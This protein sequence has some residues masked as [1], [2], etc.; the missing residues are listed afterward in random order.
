MA[1]GIPGLITESACIFTQ[2]CFLFVSNHSLFN[3][4]HWSPK[5]VLAWII[6]DDL[7]KSLV[8]S[9]KILFSNKMELIASM[10]VSFKKPPFNHLT[11][12]YSS[13]KEIWKK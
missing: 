8:T 5:L 10:Y 9:T 6:Q 11:T 13:Q 12:Q 1:V 2:P 4:I 7:S 3:I